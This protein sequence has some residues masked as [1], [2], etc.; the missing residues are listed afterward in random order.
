MSKI[1]NIVLVVD[2]DF[3]VR[4]S[5]KFAL[6]LDG[7]KVHA[8]GSGAELLAHPELDRARC[9][10]LDYKMPRMDGFEVLKHLAAR[11]VDLPVILIAGPVTDALR[12]RADEA[13][14]FS[15]LEK[16]LLDNTLLKKIRE[17]VA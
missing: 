8:C 10:V 2:D 13:G 12:E 9:L 1:G 16:P 4:E 15:I 17:V 6:E 11:K 7:L 5:L 3:D 14:V